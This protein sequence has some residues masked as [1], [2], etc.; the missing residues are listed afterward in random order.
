MLSNL[1]LKLSLINH[2]QYLPEEWYKPQSELFNNQSELHWSHK[3]FTNNLIL[4]MSKDFQLL[5]KVKECKCHSEQ[6]TCQFTELQ[7][8]MLHKTLL[9][10]L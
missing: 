7:L 8:A 4:K 5:D 3:L 2:Y 1:H 10:E 6:V 9:E